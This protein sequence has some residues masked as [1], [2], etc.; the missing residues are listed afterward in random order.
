[1]IHYGLVFGYGQKQDGQIDGQTMDRCRKA[2]KL[3]RQGRIQKVY[4]TVSAE[5]N[6][7][8][9][10]ETMR[11]Y[12]VQNSIKPTDIIVDRRGRNTAGE[13]DIFLS[14]I[15]DDAQTR[16][17]FISTWYHIPR[18]I[19]LALWRFPLGYFSVGIARRHAHLRADVLVEFKKV[20]NAIM[21]PRR[22]SKVLSFPPT[23]NPAKQ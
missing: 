22:S 15:P 19:W 20:V 14:L 10:A 5:K 7:T 17:M 2:I 18:I 11:D 6:G 23:Q 1:M 8:S 16:V 4:L 12:L 21:W 13:M 9:M 3:Y